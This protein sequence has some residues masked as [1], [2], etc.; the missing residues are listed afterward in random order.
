MKIIN[1]LLSPEN[2][3]EMT[4]LSSPNHGEVLDENAF[5]ILHYTNE[6]D[7]ESTI[8]RFMDPRS[9]VSAH[10]VV[11]RDGKVTQLIPFNLAAWHAGISSWGNYHDLNT[12]SVGIELE[13]AGILQH[14]G[15][16][17]VSTFGKP[18]PDDEVLVTNHK[19]NPNVNYGW[20][21]YTRIQI[22]TITEIIAEL[23]HVYGFREILGHDDIAPKR[24]WDP[25]PAFPIEQIRFSLSGSINQNTAESNKE[26][27]VQSS[28]DSENTSEQEDDT[29]SS[30]HENSKVRLPQ[31]KN[32]R[33]QVENG[34][35]GKTTEYTWSTSFKPV[36]LLPVPFI[37]DIGVNIPSQ[38]IDC[39]AVSASMLINAYLNEQI[40]PEDFFTNYS[41][42]GYPYL[43]VVQLRNGL[44]SLGILTD[45]H[46][47][48]TIQDLFGFLAA[49]KPPI[50][51]LKYNVFEKAGLVERNFKGPYF[52]V[53]VGMDIKNIYLHDP[54]FSTAEEGNAHAFPL[55]I[56]WKAWK[57]VT[58][59]PLFPNPERSAIVPTSGIGFKLARTVRVNQISL[60][61]RSGP[62]SDFPVVGTAKKGEFYDISREMS[63]WGEIGKDRWL[64]MAYTLPA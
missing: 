46:A 21:K 1:H 25:G 44:G 6:S 31:L 23:M 59:D 36:V 27:P 56:F 63:G 43:N 45:F 7:S 29:E 15:N 26:V 18:F 41:V 39:A 14:N 48:L 54:L 50:V 51:L 47:N 30:L 20:Q 33:Y 9:Q 28:P 5:I 35:T 19:N 37:T 61:I 11:G 4:Y 32:T 62:G 40:N 2:G 34:D 53:V 13:N 55:D 57:D 22:E 49:G 17:W 10:I 64:V 24:K 3:T 16:E 8:K 42:Q 60:N 52:S 58:N 12:F 38:Q